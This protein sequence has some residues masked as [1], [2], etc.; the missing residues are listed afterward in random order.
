MIYLTMSSRLEE[1][2]YK[3]VNVSYNKTDAF[4]PQRFGKL[5]GEEKKFFF[6][7]KALTRTKLEDDQT[8]HADHLGHVTFG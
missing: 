7:H 6:C 8:Q 5:A 2:K 4:S 3:V 1:E